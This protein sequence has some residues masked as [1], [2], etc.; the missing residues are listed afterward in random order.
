MQKVGE[1]IKLHSFLRQTEDMGIDYRRDSFLRRVVEMILLRELRLIKHKSRI[2]VREGITLFGVLD[3]TG[4]LG[5]GQVYVT[6]DTEEDRYAQPPGS[7]LLLVTRS[8]ALHPGDV[9]IAYNKLPPEGHPL[10][11]LRNCIVF[12]KLGS[13][14]LPSQ[15]SG[16][17]LDGDVFHVIWDSEVVTAV[18]THPPADYGRVKPPELDRPVTMADMAAFF[19]DFMKTDQL[20]VI[21]TRHMIL[22]D[23]M[24]EGT[25]NQNCITLAE[26]HSAA[27]DFSKTGQAVDLSRAP[28]VQK[29]RP[30]YLAPGPSIKV[31]D[32]LEIVLDD[33]V[34]PENIDSDDDDDQPQ[35]KY[36]KSDKIIGKLYRAVDERK[37]WCEDIKQII[38]SGGQ[39]F[40]DEMLAALEKRASEVGPVEWWHRLDHAKAILETYEDVLFGLMVNFSE[41]PHQPLTEHE[42]FVGFIMNKRGLQTPRQ[43]DRSIK[44]KDEFERIATLITHEMRNPPSISGHASELAALECC[45]ACIQVGRERRSKEARPNR[46]RSARHPESFKIIAAAA[47]VRELDRLE[48]KR[49]GN[50]YLSDCD[51]ILAARFQQALDLRY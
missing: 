1:S 23:Q 3:E 36:Y 44:L 28:R 39:S 37:I 4:Y 26:L 43:R 31:H 27:V 6:F 41:N 7:G 51:E 18:K 10:T 42:V 17:D 45:L 16:G 33:Q 30:D 22:A 19:V 40:W 34:V 13:R 46:R 25:L 38:E 29:W 5:E 12:S 14:D 48:K 8:P 32:K 49:V 50:K 47:L 20:G 11:E 9:Q 35:H 2:P 24:Q 21:A 15:L